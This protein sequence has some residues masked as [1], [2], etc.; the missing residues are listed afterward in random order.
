MA[1]LVK[2]II[3]RGIPGFRHSFLVTGPYY[4]DQLKQQMRRV[5]AAHLIAGDDEGALYPTLERKKD[6]S[7]L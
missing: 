1:N 2:A 3:H 6:L 5:A 4:M 7:A